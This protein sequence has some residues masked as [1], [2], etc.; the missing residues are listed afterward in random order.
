MNIEEEI[1][2]KIRNEC[3]KY[4]REGRSIAAVIMPLVKRAQAEAWEHAISAAQESYE[5][6]YYDPWKRLIDNPYIE[7]E[8]ERA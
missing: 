2:W 6:D 1:A 4:I 3:N 5:C 7:N 8:G